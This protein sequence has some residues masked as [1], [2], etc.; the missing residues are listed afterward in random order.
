LYLALLMKVGIS[1]L[2]ALLFSFSSF[3]QAKFQRPVAR[4]NI[5]LEM[6]G[7]GIIYSVNYEGA[8][9]R[10]PGFSIMARLGINVSPPFIVNSDLNLL[11]GITILF[12]KSREFL[13]LGFYNLNLVAAGE[14]QTKNML[15]GNIG[16]RFQPF[17]SNSIIM[18]INFTPFYLPERL[19]DPDNS[20]W[21]PYGGFSIGYAFQ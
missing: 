4:N 3:G 6:L 21:I 13:E 14:H 10:N 17:P 16:Y 2:I 18:R 1:Y 5:Y 19:G 8:L 15:T 7:N 20:A 11:S 9:F 12:G